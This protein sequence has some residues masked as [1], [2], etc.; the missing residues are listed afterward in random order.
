[1]SDETS[2]EMGR[3]Q[4]AEVEAVKEKVKAAAEALECPRQ[5]EQDQATNISTPPKSAQQKE[6]KTR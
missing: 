3:E 4:T 5:T 6:E 1:M 2:S